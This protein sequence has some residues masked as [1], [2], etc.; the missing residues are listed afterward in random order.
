MLKGVHPALDAEALRVA[1]LL[2]GHYRPG[3]QNGR[4]IDVSY[5]IPVTFS[6]N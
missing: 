5:T 4:A 6:H 2:N 1:R 3:K